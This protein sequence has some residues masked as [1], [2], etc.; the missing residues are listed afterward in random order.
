[1]VPSV[2]YI[3]KFWEPGHETHKIV[4]DLNIGE[5]NEMELFTL[6]SWPS[7]KSGLGRS[8]I[9]EV[10]HGV[11]RKKLGN[12]NLVNVKLC[13]LQRTLWSTNDDINLKR[14]H[15]ETSLI[16]DSTGAFSEEGFNSMTL[17]SEVLSSILKSGEFESSTNADDRVVNYTARLFESVKLCSTHGF[18]ISI[19]FRRKE[20]FEWGKI[21]T[22]HYPAVCL[23]FHQTFALKEILIFR[24]TLE[25]FF[26]VLFKQP[27]TFNTTWLSDSSG[28]PYEVH[29]RRYLPETYFLNRSSAEVI[30]YFTDFLDL[31]FGFYYTNKEAIDTF[32]FAFSDYKMDNSSKFIDY[33]AALEKLHRIH[34]PEKSQLNAKDSNKLEQFEKLEIDNN[35]KG[36]I[37]ANLRTEKTVYLSNRMKDIIKTS[38]TW[39]ESTR[40]LINDEEL[41]KI[42]DTRHFF[43]HLNEEQGKNAYSADDL[44]GVNEKLAELFF[45]FVRMKMDAMGN[46]KNTTTE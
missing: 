18:D 10:V 36:W 20:L 45:A 39:I 41:K 13:K 11:V 33:I 22:I 1:M 31:W 24:H 16:G 23:K 32:F 38:S 44:N 19:D 8:E 34:Y 28:V 37:R 35:L 17:H 9:I 43:A 25:R 2:T 3:G 26:A 6:E 5:H 12:G 14:Y 29:Q 42:I 15:V 30:R 27:F 40:Y 21:T 46:L 7:T 4:C